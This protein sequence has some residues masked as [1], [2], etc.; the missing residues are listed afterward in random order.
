VIDSAREANKADQSIDISESYSTI[1]PES[2]SGKLLL[3]GFL[4]STVAGLGYM[5][6]RRRGSN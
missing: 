3:V 1:M 2:A 5:A 4:L 6:M